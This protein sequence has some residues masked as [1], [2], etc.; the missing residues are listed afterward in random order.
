MLQ[1][2]TFCPSKEYYKDL[3]ATASSSSSS[4]NNDTSLS[5]NNSNNI[6]RASFSGSAAKQRGRYVF[7][8]TI[9]TFRKVEKDDEGNV[10]PIADTTYVSKQTYVE[11]EVSCYLLLRGVT[12]AQAVA[13]PSSSSDALSDGQ[14]IRWSM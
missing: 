2:L 9:N 8:S 11:Y 14:E 4:V 13:T 12:S 6:S 10:I 7:F 3:V 1:S 5:N